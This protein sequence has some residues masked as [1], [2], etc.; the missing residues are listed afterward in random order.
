VTDSTFQGL[1]V[2]AITPGSPSDKAGVKVGDVILFANGIR[3]DSAAAYVEARQIKPHQLDVTI[4]RGAQ[5][6]DL[7]LSY[8]AE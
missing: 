4:Q 8:P 5:I 6:L 1:P 2:L 7:S 3:I